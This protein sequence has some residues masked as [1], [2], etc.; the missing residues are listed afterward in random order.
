MK[1]FMQF[2]D[3]RLSFCLHSFPSC[4]LMLLQSFT[5][6]KKSHPAFGVNQEFVP[7][8]HRLVR[9]NSKRKYLALLLTPLIPLWTDQDRRPKYLELHSHSLWPP[10]VACG[11]SPFHLCQT[12]A[13]TQIS[14]SWTPTTVFS[15]PLTF[16]A[17][18]S[19]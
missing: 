9:S 12:T 2:K 6:Q 17:Q 7:K 13:R 3:H 15:L 8:S 1:T 11:D 5:D 14:C 4:N 19:V 16:P 10:R 18:D